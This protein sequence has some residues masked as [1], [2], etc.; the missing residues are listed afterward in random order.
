MLDIFEEF[1]INKPKKKSSSP[2]LGELYRAE[3]MKKNYKVCGL[4]V[5]LKTGK[6]S[7]ILQS[8]DRRKGLHLELDSFCQ[9]FTLIKEDEQLSD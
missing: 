5:D 2:H 6:Q 1:I 9:I 7:V 4:G 3:S 8:L